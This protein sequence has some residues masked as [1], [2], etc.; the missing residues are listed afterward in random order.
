MHY[1]I[2]MSQTPQSVKSA[3]RCIESGK[4]YGLEIQKWE[5]TTPNELL[6]AFISDAGFNAIGFVERYSRL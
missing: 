4:K 5:A 6:P 2:T 1:V 3:E